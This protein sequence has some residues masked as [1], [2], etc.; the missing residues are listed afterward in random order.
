MKKVFL[1]A[2]GVFASIPGIGIIVSGLGTPPGYSKLFGGVI[3]AFGALAILLLATSKGKVQKLPARQVMKTV[4]ILAIASLCLVVLYLQ[5]SALCIVTHPIHGTVYYPLWS[6]GHLAQMLDLAGGRYAAV[7]RYGFYPVSK[8]IQEAPNYPLSM[9]VTTALLLLVYQGIF[10]ALTVAFGILGLR[11]D[12]SAISALG[13]A[14]GQGSRKQA[15]N[16]AA[17]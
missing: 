14:A 3:E 16:T 17:G 15:K 11:S 2:S 7:D 4:I 8:A 13:V 5:L 1:A 6:S 9:V 10:T 12:K